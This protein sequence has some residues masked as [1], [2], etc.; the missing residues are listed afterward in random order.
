MGAEPACLNGSGTCINT[1]LLHP[2]R[3]VLPGW[4][5][6]INALMLAPVA[7]HRALVRIKRNVEQWLWDGVIGM[8]PQISHRARDFLL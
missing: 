1:P 3:Y 5:N 7:A 6:D 4:Q 2:T 8:H